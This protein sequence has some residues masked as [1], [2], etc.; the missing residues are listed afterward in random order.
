M[1]SFKKASW[2]MMQQTKASSA[3]GF[4]T[5]LPS[6]PVAM[7][8][9]KTFVKRK[10]SHYGV[11]GLKGMAEL[12][13]KYDLGT[14]KLLGKGSF[15]SV[16]VVKKRVTKEEFALKVVK[17]QEVDTIE[18]LRQEITMQASLDHPN[19]AKVFEWFEDEPH[20]ELAIV[21][22]YLTGGSLQQRIDTKRSFPEREVGMLLKRLCSAIGYCHTHGVV[23]R[24]IK[25]ANIMYVNKEEDA[26]IKLIDFGLAAQVAGADMMWGQMGTPKYMAPELWDDVMVYDSSVDLWAIGVVAFLLLGGT[27]PFSGK[28][29]EQLLIAIETAD[30]LYYGGTWDE[31]GD[32]AR[33]FCMALLKKDPKDRPPATQAREH[34]FIKSHITSTDSAQYMLRKSEF[35]SS[36]TSYAEADALQKLAQVVIAFS[37]QGSQLEDC[38]K[39]FQIIDTNDSGTISLDEF[40][41]A[42]VL[43]PDLDTE[44]VKNMF[45][46]MDATGS[47]EV[48]YSEF[49]SATLAAQD[50]SEA[51]IKSAFE[52]LDNDHDGFI[53][54]ADVIEAL[55]ET[56][57]RGAISDALE[58]HEGVG[59]QMG[60]EHFKEVVEAGFHL[61]SDERKSVLDGR[62]SMVD[63]LQRRSV[64]R[65]SDA[66]GRSSRW[67]NYGDLPETSLT[68]DILEAS[69]KIKESSTSAYGST[70][71]SISA[72]SIETA[73]I[74]EK[75]FYVEQELQNS[76]K[77]GAS[78]KHA[79]IKQ[80]AE[81]ANRSQMKSELN[82]KL[83]K[84]AAMPTDELKTK[85]L[86]NSFRL[87]A[88]VTFT[89][90]QPEQS[91]SPKPSDNHLVA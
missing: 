63:A 58:C 66:S 42:M 57:S 34:P 15:A 11:V 10:T 70:L 50:H 52:M 28:T 84:L 59:G 49:L 1:A 43:F 2:H 65:R 16:I 36:I 75:M 6:K 82:Q 39:M 21:M 20:A 60:Y 5:D 32:D 33:K 18:E 87:K 86:S 22:E 85:V 25:P 88:K 7:P 91:G 29:R 38:R 90:D 79:K 89:M 73:A 8:V 35:V 40:Q 19:I 47:G 9:S 67:E 83:A 77:A 3:S 76:S 72:L 31:R 54:H 27:L 14:G 37:K 61:S 13:S 80:L 68:K 62:L 69:L 26:E 44:Q 53:S 41:S 51:D 64:I 30:P 71:S 81:E 74:F 17:I 12:E 48:D 24:D 56:L 4:A 78:L 23:H 46:Q 55:Q 45:V